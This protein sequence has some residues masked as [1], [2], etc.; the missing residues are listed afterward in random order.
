M[1]VQKQILKKEKKEKT[2]TDD[3]EGET[4]SEEGDEEGEEGS[5]EGS[6]E[7]SGTQ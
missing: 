7:T 6:T 1:L 3:S 2:E 5:E 4:D